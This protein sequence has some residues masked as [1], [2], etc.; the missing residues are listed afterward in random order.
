LTWLTSAVNRDGRRPKPALA[1]PEPGEPA[2]E[3]ADQA[4]SGWKSRLSAITSRAAIS[5]AMVAVSQVDGPP[6]TQNKIHGMNP[7]IG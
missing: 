4:T 6:M 1:E 3:P 5:A 2:P 7:T